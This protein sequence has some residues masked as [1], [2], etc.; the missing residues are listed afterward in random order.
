MELFPQLL[1]SNYIL[2]EFRSEDLDE[3]F[4]ALSHPLVIKHYGI[5]YKTKQATKEQMSW[6]KQI[7]E[8]GSGMWWAIESLKS[9]GVLVG[10]IGVNS[11]SHVH[12]KAEMGYWLLP[13]HFG[14]GVMSECVATVIDHLFT[15]TRL[16]RIEANVESENERSTNLLLKNG[17]LYEGTFVKSEWKNGRYIDIQYYARLRTDA[18]PSS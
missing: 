17:F 1:S 15:K 9:P 18:Q 7:F 13:E 11:W 14:K 16:H 10:G 8:E 4:R 6:F 2:R 12:N 3:V 5:S